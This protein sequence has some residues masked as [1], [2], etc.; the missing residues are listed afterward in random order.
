MI[1]LFLRLGRLIAFIYKYGKVASAF[2]ILWFFKGLAWF[3]GLFAF[4][5]A[6]AASNATTGIGI[7]GVIYSLQGVIWVASLFLTFMVAWFGS[8][9]IGFFLDITGIQGYIDELIEPLKN[10]GKTFDKIGG[11]TSNV[12]STKTIVGSALGN[13]SFDDVVD[14][15][16]FLDYLD[17]ALAAVF[18]FLALKINIIVW[19]NFLKSASSPTKGTRGGLGGNKVTGV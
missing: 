14:Y 7:M 4:T 3:K 9:V 5:A 2:I 17:Y 11:V 8:D 6:S 10:A 12:T 18:G 19:Q 16:S 13:V 15:F 1:W